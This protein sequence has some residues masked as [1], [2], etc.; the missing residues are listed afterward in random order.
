VPIIVMTASGGP[1][2]WKLLAALGADRFIVKPVNLDDVV[3]SL[4]SAVRER[5]SSPPNAPAAR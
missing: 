4:R 3:A 1:Q 2:D 5:S